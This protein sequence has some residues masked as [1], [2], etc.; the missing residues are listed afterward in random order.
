MSRHV[1]MA[2]PWT[3]APLHPLSEMREEVAARS[4]H[5]HILCQQFSIP[6]SIP[7]IFAYPD[8]I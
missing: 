6:Q 7:F 8:K 4:S 2:F 1:S 5:L 3:Q